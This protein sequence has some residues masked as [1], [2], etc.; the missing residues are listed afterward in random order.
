VD[1]KEARNRLS[2]AEERKSKCP[3]VTP[4]DLDQL[5]KLQGRIRDAE[6]KIEAQ[7]LRA[8]LKADDG[9]RVLMSR[10]TQSPEEIVLLEGSERE[11]EVSGRVSVSIGSVTLAVE[12]AM[13]DLDHLL[14]IR[15]E[16][17]EDLEKELLR[18]GHRDAAAAGAAAGVWREADAEVRNRRD[19]LAESLKGKSEAEWEA[20]GRGLESLPQCRPLATVL[21]EKLREEQELDR[22]EKALEAD[23]RSVA[24]WTAK[25][26]ALERLGDACLDLG[27]KELSARQKLDKLAPYPD[28]FVDIATFDK[29]LRDRRE[30]LTRAEREAASSREAIAGLPSSDGGDLDNLRFEAERKRLIHERL[31]QSLESQQRVARAIDAMRGDRDPFEIIHERVA[32]LFERHSGETYPSIQSYS[33]LPTAVVRENMVIPIERL[34]QGTAAS[35]ALAVRVALA[36]YCLGIAPAFVLLDD[37]FVDLDAD[38]RAHAAAVLREL[39]SRTQVIMLTC[40]EH[41]AE[42]LGP[43]RVQ[44]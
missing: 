26:G 35:L 25:Y 29:V 27:I 44:V 31:L 1:I 36:E 28:G 11:F 34:S 21:E 39:G 41:H 12:S 30:Q 38:R 16:A 20:I 7:K 10:G 2:E 40:H 8:R 19:R 37:P 9:C 4:A 17:R 18:L 24:E 33:G 32:R 43:G 6:I 13:E 14:S 15:S 22:I 5:N 23:R 42:E 3:A